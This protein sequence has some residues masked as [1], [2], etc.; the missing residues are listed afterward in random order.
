MTTPDP[1]PTDLA[2]IKVEC[3]AEHELSHTLL[4]DRAVHQAA[5]ESMEPALLVIGLLRRGC[6]ESAGAVIE[7]TGADGQHVS[8]RW[9]PIWRLPGRMSQRRYE[10]SICGRSVGEFVCD[11]VRCV[12]ADDDLRT[13]LRWYRET[14]RPASE[15]VRFLSRWVIVE[16]RIGCWASSQE[17]RF[18]VPRTEWTAIREPVARAIKAI[19]AEEG[20][21]RRVRERLVSELS[22]VNERRPDEHLEEWLSRHGYGLPDEH[23]P[24]AL[25]ELRSKLVHTGGINAKQEDSIRVSG[26][27]AGALAEGLLMHSLGFLPVSASYFANGG[28]P[29]EWKPVEQG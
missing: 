7:T 2:V 24:K 9:G 6:V 1:I 11:G 3:P 18:F 16:Q 12:R 27:L 15:E 22:R 8:P 21:R 19:P 25:W 14:M 5:A 4:Q 13:A 20:V 28:V 17:L 23:P 10:N 29:P 26:A